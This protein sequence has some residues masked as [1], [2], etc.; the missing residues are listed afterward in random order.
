[1]KILVGFFYFSGIKA[2]Y[3]ALTANPKIRLRVLVGLETER[4]LGRLVECSLD[5][6][7]DFGRRVP[8]SDFEIA[9]RFLASL[10]RTVNAP[11]LDKQNF[12]ER[13]G[14]FLELLRSGRLQ[15]R[16]T[17]EPNHAK[18]YLF[19]LAG[20]AALLSRSAWITGSSNLTLPGLTAQAE[21]N[22]EIH[23]FGNDE[24]QKL[25]EE[26]WADAVPLTENAQVLRE[27]IQL[28]TEESVV[29]PVTPFEAYVM[30]LKAYL[31]QQSQAAAGVRLERLLD[32]KGFRRYQYQLDAV[33]QALTILKEYNGVIIADVVGLGK[34]VIASMIARASAKRGIVIAPPGLLGDEKKRTSGW[35]QYRNAFKLHGWELFSSGL[36]ENALEYVRNEDDIEMV[37]VDEAHRFKN[38]D[39]QDYETLCNICRGRQVILLTATPFNNKPADIFALLKLFILPNKSKITLDNHLADRFTSYDAM[40]R[41]L[42]DVQKHFRSADPDK[43][44]RAHRAYA[45]LHRHL[46]GF[47]CGDGAAVNPSLVM[48]WA[49]QLAREIRQLLEPV[50]IRRNR[51]DLRSDPDYCQEV[52]ELSQMQPPVEQFFELTP[53]QLEFYED[54][55]HRCFGEGGAFKGAIYQPFAYERQAL[56]EL[57]EQANRELHQQSNLYDFMR[58]LLVKRFESS[59]GS[60]RQSIENFE[61]VHLKVRQ[62]I[63]KTGKLILDRTVVERIYDKDEDEIG[64]AMEAFSAA[65]EESTRPRNARIYE[66]GEF[67]AADQFLADVDS[68]IELFGEIRRRMDELGLCAADP[69]LEKLIEVVGTVLEGRHPGIPSLAGEPPRKVIVF[70]EYADTIRHLSEGLAPRFHGSMLSVAGSLSVGLA[71]AIERNFDASVKAVDQRND[72]QVLLATDK[73]SEGYNLNRAGVVI[74]YDIPWNPTRVIQRVGR[75]NRI[76]NKVFENL[77]IFNFFPTEVGAPI[78]KSREIATQ[79]MFMIH[80]TIGEDAQIFDIDETPTASSLY[81]KMQQ[82][83]E[84]A[85]QESFLTRVKKALAQVKRDHPEVLEKVARLPFRVKT[86][87]TAADRPGLIV[88][89]KKGLG[90]FAIHVEDGEAAKVEALAIVHAVESIQC[91]Y[92]EPRLELGPAFW[93]R[94]AKAGEFHESFRGSTR[95]SISLESTARNNLSSAV[96]LARESGHGELLAFLRTLLHDIQ[97]YGSLPDYTLRRIVRNEARA[98][99]PASL[100]RFFTEIAR[101]RSEVGENYLESIKRTLNYSASEIIIA[102]EN[103]REGD[104]AAT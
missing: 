12:H 13:F 88:F 69:K 24:V 49:R 17:R 95:S 20:D 98:D 5:E 67:A 73:M 44:K 7:D 57:D 53:A 48:T 29:A 68:D 87:R 52:R 3:E 60:F 41:R 28:L 93:P 45:V 2:L 82:N 37:V 90:L 6:T 54:I 55:I 18:L 4:I 92:P 65:M 36:L 34:S 19:D 32:G 26:L 70:S 25:F 86:A 11:E 8:V 71:E 84:D 94:Y 31:D 91:E 85:E 58:R 9:E 21:L 74:N 10:R 97:N 30:V 83:P 22:V 63:R 77:Y 72:C 101:I 100:E 59:F 33:S 15:L 62:F 56:G 38:Q 61:R 47:E 43:R 104:S 39:T 81:Q 14:F 16:K 35:Q 76:G 50:I 23:D 102:V 78:A 96:S 40:F 75:I 27:M 99:A 66:V 80:N 51:L 103:R 79:K 89:K 42:S 1:M 46:L 64:T